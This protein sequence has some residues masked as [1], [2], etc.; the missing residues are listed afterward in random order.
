MKTLRLLTIL[1][2]LLAGCSATPTATAIPTTVVEPT[3]T[4]APAATETAVPSPTETAVPT[5]VP[6]TSTPTA[7]QQAQAIILPLVAPCT[8]AGDHAISYSP[9]NTWVIANCQA[10]NPEDGI[11][12]KF[13]RMDGSQQWSISF[14]EIFIKP[15]RSADPNRSELLQ[16]TFVP[17][18]WTLNEDFVY[19]AAPTAND[20]TAY[21]GYYGLFQF[22]LSNGKSAATLPPAMAP[23]KTTYALRY[24]PYGNK[25]AYIN[26][27]VSP[28]TIMIDDTV[29]GDQQQ[30]KLD[31]RFIQGGSLLWSDDETKLIVSVLDESANGGNSVIVYDLE[32]NKNEFILKNSDHTYLP[33]AW[34]DEN[35]IYAEDYPGNWVYIDLSTKAVSQAPAPTPA[36]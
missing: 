34:M 17:V 23:I 1:T 16:K 11:I 8:F 6:A 35:T 12:Q 33:V 27:Y 24:S 32:A 13:A 7:N 26:Q 15:Y 14:N 10:E 30:I 36:P 5:A 22:N 21:K 25:L 3:A 9:N 31:A 20:E 29:T 2:F 18:R 28:V 4:T 19:L